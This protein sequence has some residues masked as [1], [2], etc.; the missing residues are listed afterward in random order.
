V[1]I[2]FTLRGGV[3]AKRLRIPGVVHFT[4]IN[5]AKIVHTRNS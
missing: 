5:T 3:S 1:N 4:K 2:K